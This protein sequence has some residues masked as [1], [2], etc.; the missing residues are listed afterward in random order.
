MRDN[1]RKANF[2]RSTDF[3]VKVDVEVTNHFVVY[4]HSHQGYWNKEARIVQS[5][6][7]ATLIDTDMSNSYYNKLLK[8]IYLSVAEVGILE[9]KTICKGN[10]R[11]IREL[12]V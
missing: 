5:I 11:T 4:S 12:D 8:E 2:S 3:K 7:H 6:E 9:I 1:H 10:K